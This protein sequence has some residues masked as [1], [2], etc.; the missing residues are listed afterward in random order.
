MKIEMIKEAGGVFR[1]VSD[2][3][4]EKTVKFKTGEQYT[5]EIKL[6]RNP[7]FHRKVFAFFNFCFNYWKGDNEFQS[8]T[9]QFDVF[10]NHL[11]VLAGFYEQH[12]SI[13]GDL[14]VEAKSLSFSSMSQEE[15]EECYNS[16]IRASMKHVFKTADE[17]TYQ[18]LLSFF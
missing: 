8:E 9:K 12:S 6:T 11:T 2:M 14:R 18:Q 4:Y 5:V 3:E 17:N 1:P 15:F 13:H 7:K 16:L 10:R